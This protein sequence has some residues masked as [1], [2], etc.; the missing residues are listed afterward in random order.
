MSL[1]CCPRV[2]S[3][4][5][6]KAKTAAHQALRMTR[7]MLAFVIASLR[8]ETSERGFFR[9]ERQV[10]A[11]H[12]QTVLGVVCYSTSK[13]V[14]MNEENLWCLLLLTNYS[15]SYVGTVR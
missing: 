6:T 7:L 2:P 1:F 13:E 12:G 3:L 14:A 10:I 11:G 15:Y 4:V 5:L 8:V 9:V